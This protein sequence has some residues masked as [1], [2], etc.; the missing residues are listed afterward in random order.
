LAASVLPA[1]GAHIWAAFLRIRRRKGGNG[2]GPEPIGWPDIAAFMAAARYPLA[3]WEVEI[4]EDLDDAY[5]A[6]QARNAKQ[7]QTP[8]PKK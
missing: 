1:A 5:I 7:P 4:I 6:E 3:P 8:Q 2:F